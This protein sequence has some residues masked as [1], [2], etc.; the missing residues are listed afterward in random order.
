MVAKEFAGMLLMAFAGISESGLVVLSTVTKKVGIPY[1]P[2]IGSGN[3]LLLISLMCLGHKDLQQLTCKQVKWIWLRGVFGCATF[4]L[5]LLAVAAGA[6]IGDASAL[7]TIN[8]VVAAILGRMFLGE[9]LRA[10]HVIAV[11]ASFA[12][13]VLVAKPETLLGMRRVEGGA[14]WLG[15]LCA[16]GSGLTSGVLFIASRKSQDISTTLMT[17]S[18]AAHLFVACWVVALTGLADDA[19]LNSLTL[20]PLASMAWL[21][22]LMVLDSA[23]GISTTLGSQICPAA[24][25]ST[26]FTSTQM[27]LGYVADILIHGTSPEPL[28]IAGASLMLLAVLLMALASKTEEPEEEAAPART[29]ESAGEAVANVEE[30]Q[31]IENEQDWVT[32][33]ASE[34]SGCT[35]RK[36]DM[37]QRTIR[38]AQVIGSTAV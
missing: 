14:P 7:G 2:L 31:E 29:R 15:Y 24:A 5:A 30:S 9:R 1:Y 8:V 34:F 13:A 32:F 10:I 20:S 38:A 3:L 27:T 35:P 16:L 18:L 4:M 23:N 6:P 28:T 36:T 25:S 17:S 19:P 33:A 12:G 11:G 21:V 22:G 26:I 37:R